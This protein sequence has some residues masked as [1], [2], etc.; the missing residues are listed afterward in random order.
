MSARLMPEKLTIN[1]VELISRP[2]WGCVSFAWGSWNSARTCDDGWTLFSCLR[3]LTPHYKDNWHF[4]VQS[5]IKTTYVFNFPFCCCIAIA[6]LRLSLASFLDCAV[7]NFQRNITTARRASQMKQNVGDF[8]F[9][10][11]LHCV[12]QGFLHSTA[13]ALF[14][15]L[16]LLLLYSSS[17]SDRVSTISLRLPALALMSMVQRPTSKRE[18]EFHVKLMIS[19]S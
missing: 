6:L 8:K 14:R 15:R 19:S 2:V 12:S 5:I 13:I 10:S 18:I 3:L 1:W 7:F 9:V 11:T 4:N 17:S 16:P